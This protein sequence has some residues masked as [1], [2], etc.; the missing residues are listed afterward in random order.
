MTIETQREEQNNTTKLYDLKIQHNIPLRSKTSLE[1]FS[2]F[3]QSPTDKEFSS[4]FK[5]TDEALSTLL[6]YIRHEKAQC[7]LTFLNTYF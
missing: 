2:I 7:S 6:H 5:D 1:D 3:G 4:I